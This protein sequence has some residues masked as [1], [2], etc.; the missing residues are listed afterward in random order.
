M[1]PPLGLVVQGTA[2]RGRSS[3]HRGSADPRP[4]EQITAVEWLTRLSGRRTVERIWLPL[5]RSKLGPHCRDASAAFIWA[6]IARLYA[7]RRSGLKREMFGYVEGGYAV[8]LDRLRATV[9]AR[10][11]EIRCGRPAT[12]VRGDARGAADRNVPH[13]RHPKSAERQRWRSHRA[14]VSTTSC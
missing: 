9:Q 7:A 12:A 2:R 10:G 13:G 6:I 1:F 8:V 11:V 5:L 4:L 14:S 3:P